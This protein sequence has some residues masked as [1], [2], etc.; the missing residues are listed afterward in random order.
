MISNNFGPAT[1]LTVIDNFSGFFTDKNER[2]RNNN[3]KSIC[4]KQKFTLQRLYIHIISKTQQN[5]F[6]LFLFFLSKTEITNFSEK[7][8]TYYF[9]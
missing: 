9:L 3:D 5:C 7:K 1:K 2:N 4:F 6:L 8:K